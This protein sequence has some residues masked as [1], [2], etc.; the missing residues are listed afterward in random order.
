MR[1]CDVAR[2]TGRL[3]PSVRFCLGFAEASG[4][5][6]D[7][8]VEH[9]FSDQFAGGGVDDAD[10]ETADQH[11]HGG[12]GV[13]SADADVVQPAGVAEGERA[14]AVDH[15]AADSWLRLGLWWAGRGG[16][17]SGVVAAKG[18]CRF[19]ER[20]GRRVKRHDFRAALIRA[21]PAV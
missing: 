19:R 21:A 17:G 1:H 12:S 15:V 16:F 9:E 20:C 6:I 13:G 5:V 3:E 8:W 10:V 7:G 4:L 18:V 2:H 11:Q 14:V